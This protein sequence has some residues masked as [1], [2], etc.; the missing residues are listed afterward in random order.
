ME[1]RQGYLL[2]D[3]LP[4]NPFKIPPVLTSADTKFGVHFFHCHAVKKA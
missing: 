4:L 1:I 2:L 3:E